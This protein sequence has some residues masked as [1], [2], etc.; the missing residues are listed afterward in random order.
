MLLA[1]IIGLF[2]HLL[3]LEDATIGRTDIKVQRGSRVRSS[4]YV[5]INWTIVGNLVT[6]QRFKRLWQYDVELEEPLR[7]SRDSINCIV[8]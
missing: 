4:H 6:D 3:I 5:V 7:R 2:T 8:T 1:L